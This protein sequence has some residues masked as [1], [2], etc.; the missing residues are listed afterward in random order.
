MKKS[1]F[2]AL[3]IALV[4]GTVM[5]FAPQVA[6]NSAQV[7]NYK[8]NNTATGSGQYNGTGKT[9]TGG[10]RDTS[11]G[12]D[13]TYAYFQVQY[14]SDITVVDSFYRTAAILA[15]NAKLFGTDDTTN[16]GA[17]YQVIPDT[18]T[19]SSTVGLN[20]YTSTNT[21]S[22]KCVWQASRFKWRFGRVRYIGTTGSAYQIVKVYGKY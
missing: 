21:A 15:G 5:S 19:A 10:V 2:I 9:V 4:A 1:I 6:W 17:W 12:A 7:W 16:G 18:A 20:G 13:T 3:M 22:Q 11:V 14:L 8:A